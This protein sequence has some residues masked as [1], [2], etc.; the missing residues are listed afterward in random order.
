LSSEYIPVN[1]PLITEE[2]VE[3]VSKAMRETWVSGEGKYVAEFENSFAQLCNREFG[4]AVANGTVA[5]DLV[6][7]ALELNPGDEVILP[8][9]TIV[10]CKN[11][12]LRRG[13]IPIFVDALPD[14]WNMDVT[15][16]E[17]L[18][19][20]KTRAIMAVHIYGLPVDM[21]PLLEIASRH[22]LPVIEDAAESHGLMYKEKIAGSMGLVS[23]FSFYA[24]KNIT[25][26]EGGMIVTDDSAFAEKI[27]QLK[28]LSFIPERRF[29]H[30]DL[31]WNGR[32]SSIQCALGSSQTKRLN[33][34][35]DKRVRLG[36]IYQNAFADIPNILLPK[37]STPYSR[38]NY[39]VFGI[40]LQKSFGLT[41]KEIMDILDI[42]GVGT[43][44]FFF[45]LHK[46]PLLEKFNHRKFSLP[47]SENLGEFGFYIP[48]GLG[49]VDSQVETVIGRVREVLTNHGK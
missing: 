16:V 41:A 49:M 27:R 43:R 1:I 14:T 21:D 47:V 3:Y 20:P 28:N 42:Q 25:T 24:N 45:P 12:I 44:P 48:N 36:E 39:W 19:T 10:S 30:N 7:E 33:E 32:L 22:G 17:A 40:V 9:F 26:G 29:L 38:N 23:T 34:I 5:L 31:G 6:I 13:A 35:V 4:I 18:I 15:Q 11:Q 2:D 8:S 46:Q 37:N